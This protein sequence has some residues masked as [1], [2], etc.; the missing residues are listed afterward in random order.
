MTRL[1]FSYD[2]PTVDTETEDI[3]ISMGVETTYVITKEQYTDWI[4][5]RGDFDIATVGR[6]S[7]LDHR[8]VIRQICERDLIGKIH[9]YGSDP[10]VI[11][12]DYIPSDAELVSDL[13]GKADEYERL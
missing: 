10:D 4:I 12:F 8:I 1:I 6:I 2:R 7:S 13:K 5:T 11:Q 3:G 9:E